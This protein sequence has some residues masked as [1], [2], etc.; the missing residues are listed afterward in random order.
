MTRSGSLPLAA[1]LLLLAGACSSD[2]RNTETADAAAGAD[3]P[4]A[5]TFR[6][7]YTARIPCPAGTDIL[8]IWLPLPL[9]EPG[10]QELHEL[11][12]RVQAASEIIDNRIT[13]EPRHGNRMLHV[14]VRG[15][16]EPVEVV[17]EAVVTRHEDRGQGS[18][19]L[20]EVHLRPTR[21]VPLKGEAAKLAG[22]LGVDDQEL[23][24][25]VRARTIY[26]D[27]L[28]AMEYNKEVPGYGIGD[29]NRAVTVCKGNCTDF[30]ARFM[31]VGR[32]A[33][34]PVRFTMGIP[35]GDGGAG[36]SSGYHCWA[37]FHDSGRWVPVDISEADKVEETEPSK[38]AWF[39]GHLDEDRI[40]LTR[41]RDVVL[42][43]EQKGGPLNY[44]VY[45]YAEADGEALDLDGSCCT[46]AYEDI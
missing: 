32:A 41:G 45:P 37:H 5:R 21:L 25:D 33:G 20:R 27:V 1:C 3:D 36:T 17:W 18:G 34:I 29:F 13:R 4:P 14:K 42:A 15:P 39:F 16:R 44:L 23:P 26:D 43:P 35:L 19:P 40:A 10:V 6:F 46:F 38:A 28:A 12:H 9:E 31:G 24:V 2:D 7:S 11:N 22:S 30:H 8:E